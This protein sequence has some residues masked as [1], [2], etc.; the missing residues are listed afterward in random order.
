MAVE[1]VAVAP[2]STSIGA[3]AAAS[4]SALFLRRLSASAL[5]NRSGC[6][7]LP[8]DAADSAS[9]SATAFSTSARAA[10]GTYAE[11]LVA[12]AAAKDLPQL[13][14]YYENPLLPPDLQE[15]EVAIEEAASEQLQHRTSAS[16][17]NR[18][19][20]KHCQRSTTYTSQVTE[21][22]WVDAAPYWLA[23]LQAEVED[24]KDRDGEGSLSKVDRRILRTSL[25]QR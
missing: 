25:L 14:T 2:S 13:C 1:V 5:V 8:L 24:K 9:A 6:L 18:S 20:H 4:A 10:A 21:Q 3:A 17:H 23:L 7:L 16:H 12:V 15:F 22:W 19:Q 11:R